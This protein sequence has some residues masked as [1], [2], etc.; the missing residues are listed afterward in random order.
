[1]RILCILAALVCL[2]L[3][4]LLL[5][6]GG[7]YVETY[8]VAADDGARFMARRA[9]PMFVGLAVLLWLVRDLPKGTARDAICSAMAVI[10]AGIACTGIYEYLVGVAAAPIL[11][12]AVA[13]LGIALAFV[14]V[15][16]A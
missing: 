7:M 13:E 11:L 5:T 14:V 1:M 10:F 6:N 3:F 15:R 4:A 12:A 16:R 8:G 9:A 2:I